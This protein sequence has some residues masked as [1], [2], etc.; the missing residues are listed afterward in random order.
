MG[1]GGLNKERENRLDWRERKGVIK[2]A[3][4]QKRGKARAGGAGRVSEKKK[5]LFYEGG[6]ERKP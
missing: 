3:S 1:E 2:S 4:A 5:G 6:G